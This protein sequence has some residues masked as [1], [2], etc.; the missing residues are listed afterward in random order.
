MRHEFA[1][2]V[3]KEDLSGYALSLDGCLWIWFG[4]YGP[5]ISSKNLMIKFWGKTLMRCRCLISRCAA[6]LSGHPIHRTCLWRRFLPELLSY[7]LENRCFPILLHS[8]VCDISISNRQ[9][10][11]EYYALACLH[12]KV[13]VST[14]IVCEEPQYWEEL[15]T[16]LTNIF[17]QNGLLVDSAC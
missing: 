8:F 3:R 9:H 13:F 7:F 5:L 4:K 10:G 16:E 2:K 11:N 1:L 6:W 12:F 17:K 15:R 14:D